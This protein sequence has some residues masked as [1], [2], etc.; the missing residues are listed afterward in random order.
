[1]R[2]NVRATLGLDSDAQH[3]R[4]VVVAIGAAHFL[5]GLHGGENGLEQCFSVAHGEL[6]FCRDMAAG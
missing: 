3:Q 4:H 6:A 2:R 5:G 1:M